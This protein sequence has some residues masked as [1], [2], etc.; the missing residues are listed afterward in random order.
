[1][2][3]SCLHGVKLV[4]HLK[5]TK[6]AR[7]VLFY[8]CVAVTLCV[9]FPKKSTKET[10]KER[11]KEKKNLRKHVVFHACRATSLFLFAACSL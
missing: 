8:A 5:K 6:A 2:V 11:K 3:L 9:S 10:K 4:F 7:L 1:M